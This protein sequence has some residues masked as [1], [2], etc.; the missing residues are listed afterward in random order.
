M[1]AGW[2]VWLGWDSTAG[3]WDGQTGEPVSPPLVHGGPLDHCDFS[4][5]GEVLATASGDRTVR[6]WDGR[7][8]K[9]ICPPLLH[10]QVP[11]KVSFSTDGRRLAT[12]CVDG[13]I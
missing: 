12:G 8:G 3:L 7:I 11:L 2:R 10:S 6:L 1:A 13:T 9:A 4:P 5:N